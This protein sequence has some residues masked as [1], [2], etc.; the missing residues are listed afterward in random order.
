MLQAK[1]DR[2]D[3]GPTCPDWQ[4]SNECHRLPKNVLTQ[5]NKAGHACAGRKETMLHKAVALP[6][7]SLSLLS[8]PGSMLARRSL[9]GL[10]FLLSRHPF[11]EVGN[12]GTLGQGGTASK[13][14]KKSPVLQHESRRD[15][16]ADG[17]VSPATSCHVTAAIEPR[18]P[19][20]TRGCCSYWKLGGYRTARADWRGA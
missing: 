15:A 6:M 17:R 14:L 1:L 19:G 18:Y 9:P 7:V 11:W 13:G 5:T 8:L 20:N 2:S 3:A 16:D 4:R 10:C 12:V